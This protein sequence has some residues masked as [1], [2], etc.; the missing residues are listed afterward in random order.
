MANVH[1]NPI[2]DLEDEEGFV[3]ESGELIP[4]E[5]NESFHY[6]PV[7]TTPAYHIEQA[8]KAM[9]K[10]KLVV[11]KSGWKKALTV[12][13]AIVYTKN[14]IGDNDKVP[15]FMC[16]HVIEKFSP[17]AIFAVIG[18]RKLWDPWYEEGN[19][20]ENLNDSTSLTYMVMQGVAGTRIRD[21]S[22]VEKIQ[23]SQ[24]GTIYFA[25]TSVEKVPHVVD[26]IRAHI[27]LNGWI[28]KPISYNPLR[29]KVT[30]VLQARVN[31]W[32]PSVVAKKY[33]TKRP[34][35]VLIIDQYLQRNGPPPMVISSTSSTSPLSSGRESRSE[36]NASFY[37][38]RFNNY[39]EVDQQRYRL[40]TL[41]DKKDLQEKTSL[42]SPNNRKDISFYVD[43]D[44]VSS[45]SSA[46][47]QSST[48]ELQKLDSPSMQNNNRRED[49]DDED[50]SSHSY[51]KDQPPMKEL[52]KKPSFEPQSIQNNRRGI[53]FHPDSGTVI[54]HSSSKDQS[55]IKKLNRKTSFEPQPIQNNNRRGISF[56]PDNDHS[57]SSPSYVRDQPSIKK[58]HRKTSFDSPLMRNNMREI[59]Y[60]PDSDNVSLENE[61]LPLPKS[62]KSPKQ[63]QFSSFLDQETILTQTQ[64]TNLVQSVTSPSIPLLPSPP[65]SSPPSPPSP[66]PSSIKHKHTDAVNAAVKIFKDNIKDLEGW[67]F[68]SE[69][70][71][72]KVYTKDV[73]GRSTPII[74]GD[75]TITGGYTAEDLL[76]VIKNLDLRKFWDDR[77]E[78][79][80]NIKMFD[81][82][83]IL[84]RVA[85]KGTFPISGRDFALCGTVERDPKTGSVYF[86][87]TSI[88]DSAIP[89]VKKYV[90]AHVHFTGWKIVPSFDENGDT[91]ELD[92]VY[93]VDTD[94]KLESVPQSILKSISTGTPLVVQKIDEMLQKIGFPPYIM[95]LSSLII[96]ENLDPKTFQ[97]NL[98]YVAKNGIT[99]IR[100]SKKMYPHGFDIHVVPKIAKIELLPNNQE[101][102]RITTPPSE[103]KVHI[104][105]TKYSNG[106]KMTYNENHRI[107]LASKKDVLKSKVSTENISIT[108]NYSSIKSTQPIL[109]PVKLPIEKETVRQSWRHSRNFSQPIN[110]VANG[111]E[112]GGLA[113][114]RQIHQR[115]SRVFSQ[116]TDL[117][118]ALV[119]NMVTI[120]ANVFANNDN[121]PTQK[122]QRHSQLLD[123]NATLIANE[124]IDKV[125]NENKRTSQRK[126]K[127]L[128]FA[129]TPSIINPEK[130]FEPKEDNISEIKND[131][132]NEFKEYEEI[133]K[134]FNESP[135]EHHQLINFEDDMIVISDSV[136]L[137][138]Y[139]V[140]IMFVGMVISYYAGRISCYYI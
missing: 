113:S 49:N 46:K 1:Y 117:N 86:I 98:S 29:T 26:R 25:S 71:G 30:Y 118:S 87:T 6:D 89:E 105:V 14:G 19:L 80:E 59:S 135:I 11:Q 20:I 84:S 27:Y 94:I 74:R 124:T 41:K 52:R 96:S 114:S 95:N 22:L 128:S 112:Q 44:N 104:K 24:D 123:P 130:F 77:Y 33:L 37:P 81:N 108:T 131:E 45:H 109:Q 28:I 47:D 16:Q 90:R 88:T 75:Y 125:K 31:G 139:Q 61:Q 48:K 93:V 38:T 34:L 133:I 15:V 119:A 2:S 50:S 111:N 100:F 101:I 121:N 18:M 35:V 97:Y 66:H 8:D 79:G 43:D 63:N 122:N 65:L 140:A 23:C 136:R 68:Y 92:I 83:N 40:N 67:K 78:D 107:P 76:S 53:S 32:I 102:V 7:I 57:L 5:E 9:E 64:P 134:T 62:P 120:D 39:V 69:N 58:L 56:H 91:K 17:Q 85:C 106:F 103:D 72:V 10:L 127:R 54:S 60:L 116:P 12:K 36:S 137:S 110:L 3:E 115:H 13:N 55:S 73:A 82:D 70:K 42:E 138:A 99:E 126:S 21:L 132:D 51:V 4:G 129:D